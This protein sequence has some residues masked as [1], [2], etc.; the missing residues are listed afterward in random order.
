MTNLVFRIE[1]SRF[2]KLKTAIFT[3]VG[4]V[5]PALSFR[6]RRVLA[7]QLLTRIIYGA[8]KFAAHLCDDGDF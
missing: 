8:L 2:D 3:S 4:V 1:F 6:S 5:E 7:L